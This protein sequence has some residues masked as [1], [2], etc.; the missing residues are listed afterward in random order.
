MREYVTQFFEFKPFD[1]LSS[2]LVAFLLVMAL[3]GVHNTIINTLTVGLFELIFIIVYIVSVRRFTAISRLWSSYQWVLVCTLLWFLSTTLSL[4]FAVT[5]AGIESAQLK[6]I[7]AS[8]AMFILHVAFGFCFASFLLEAGINA[9][10]F[11]WAMSVGVFGLCVFMAFL[12]L[13][14]HKGMGEFWHDGLSFAMNIRH[15]GYWMTAGSACAFSLL[16]LEDSRTKQVCLFLIAVGS[17]AMLIWMGG[18]GGVFSW[19][20]SLC[21][22]VFVAWYVGLL[23]WKKVLLMVLSVF[24]AFTLAE[25]SSVD[26]WG[27]NG[28]MRVAGTV[29]GLDGADGGGG[30]STGRTLLWKTSID[31]WRASP[32]FGLGANAYLF[33]PERVFG[34]HPHNFIIQL[35]LEWGVVGLGLFLVV[36]IFSCCHPLVRVFNTRSIAPNQ[37]VAGTVLISLLAH[38]L[39]DGIFWY[40]RPLMYI[41]LALSIYL[42][43]PQMA[44]E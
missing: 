25:M 19:L 18:R 38:A 31:A 10:R 5:Q 12:L 27:W 35:L 41:S 9:N 20:S 4:Y 21:V 3:C 30:F 32:W 1:V 39:T 2:L 37:L 8:Y 36:F 40:A 24:C 34:I 29:S 28:M 22:L 7:Y 14:G 6:A 11:L 42:T 13:I 44:N 23:T 26:D 43:A 33:L 17:A 15:I 16:L